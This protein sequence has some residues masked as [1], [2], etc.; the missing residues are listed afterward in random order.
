M[1]KIIFSAGIIFLAGFSTVFANDGPAMVS[2]QVLESFKDKFSGAS[3]VSWKEERELDVATFRFDGLIFFAYFDK[4]GEWVATARNILSSQLPIPLLM[5]LK[6]D[7]Q[8]FWI[9][10]LMEVDSQSGTSYYITVENSSKTLL[11][12]STGYNDWAV[13]IKFKK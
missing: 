5:Q 6:K 12:R 3:E 13:N 10:A 4:Q 8:G 9:S 11:L 2:K 1:K 7:Y